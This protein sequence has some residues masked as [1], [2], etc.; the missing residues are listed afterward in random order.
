MANNSNQNKS[1]KLSNLQRN[2]PDSASIISKLN[3]DLNKVNTNPLFSNIP[4][5]AVASNNKTKYNNDIVQLFPDIELAIQILVSS[6]L[7]PNDM[8]TVKLS[9]ESPDINITS[10]IKKSILDMISTHMDKYYNITNKLSLI[11]RESLFTKGSYVEVIIPESSLD[12]IIAQRDIANVALESDIGK[13]FRQSYGFL[14]TDKTTDS[15]N[16]S[17]ESFAEFKFKPN[18]ETEKIIIG[19]ED[20]GFNFTEDFSILKL[21]K[22]LYDNVEKQTK[23]KIGINIGIEN[24]EETELLNKYF[25]DSTQYLAK[26]Y[27]EIPIQEDSSRKSLSRPLVF[28]IP[29][30]SVIPVHAKC[31]VSKHLGYFIILDTN[32]N[33]LID[34]SGMMKENEEKYSSEEY[35]NNSSKLRLI[36]KVTQALTG[37]TKEAPRLDNLESVYSKLVENM[38]KKKLKSGAYGELVDIKDNADIFRV[39]FYR[40]LE[41]QQTQLLFIPNELVAY[42]AF[43]YRENGT[44]KSLMEK[45]SVLYSIRSIIL[46][47]RLMAYIKNATTQT[48]VSV[49]LDEKIPDPHGTFTSIQSEVLNTRKDM[50]PVGVMNIG[51][52]VDWIQ[53]LGIR[54]KVQ[55]PSLP[56]I[57]ISTS[58]I[59]SSKAEPDSQLDEIIQEAILMSFGLSP[60]IVKAGYETDFATSVI[61]KNLLLAKRVIRLQEQFIPMVTQHI[62]KIMLNDVVLKERISNLIRDNLKSI[63]KTISKSSDEQYKDISKIKGEKLIEY[64]ANIFINETSVYLPTPETY[65]A[66]NAKAAFDDFKTTLEES[67]DIIFSSESMPSEIIGEM[68]NNIDMIKNQFKSVLL[69]QWM[70]ENNYMPELHDFIT[71]DEEG[72]PKFNVLEEHRTFLNA[73]HESLVPFLK[74]VNKDKIKLDEKLDKAIN[75]DSSSSSDSYNDDDDTSDENEDNNE[76]NDTNDENEDNNDTN[77]DMNADS[78]SSDDDMNAD[79]ESSDD[80]FGDD[81]GDDFDE[82][83]D[84][85]GDKDEGKSPDVLKLEKELL[86]ARVRKEQALAD[87]A[88]ANSL[89]ARNDYQNKY[90]KELDDKK[91]PYDSAGVKPEQNSKPRNDEDIKDTDFDMDNK[92][93]DMNA[94]NDGEEETPT[95]DDYKPKLRTYVNHVFN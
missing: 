88:E 47:T 21:P 52:L 14:G 37:I 2:Y 64:L 95:T 28:K 61:A 25:R 77:D 13:Y 89:Q 34:Q 50:L 41:S 1:S 43:D 45:V 39:M 79:S 38:I 48:E 92:D 80:D 5:I 12:D 82:G 71:K 84:D 72:K 66:N 68:S 74:Q 75:Q 53:K 11:L 46:F 16:I 65:E 24:D 15:I 4:N 8:T 87:K 36:R 73:I 35:N 76:N 22:L 10:E 40:A 31:D 85:G 51:D 78:E 81:F 3:S 26:P 70:S 86:E 44:G 63:K 91:T 33:P 6:I 56:R 58:D 83:L 69:R 9:Y 30:E 60:E 29:S 49:D 27:I 18:S 55:H 62:R 93:D 7:T 23:R 90:G 42:Y 19:L 54:F 17:Q 59:N 67:M 94:D 20:L 57:D 32:G